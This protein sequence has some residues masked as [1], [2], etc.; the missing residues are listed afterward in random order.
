MH[1][2]LIL[3]RMH[4]VEP[5]LSDPLLSVTLIIWNR[6]WTIK[7]EKDQ[8]TLIEQSTILIK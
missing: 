2:I 3:V 6:I 1:V 8:D 7:I 4:T 5:R